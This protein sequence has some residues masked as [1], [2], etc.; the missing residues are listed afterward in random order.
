MMEKAKYWATARVFDEATRSEIAQLIE[1][2]AV[3]ELEERFHSE[4]E[5]GTAGFRGILGAGTARLNRYT[6]RRIIG[7]LGRGL[8]KNSRVGVTYD[9]RRQSAELAHHVAEVLAGFGHHVLLTAKLQPVPLLS[10]L[11]REEECAAG[12]AVTASHNPPEYN[13]IKI[14]GSTGKQLSGDAEKALLAGLAAETDL[15]NIPVKRFDEAVEQGYVESIGRDLENAYLERIR[16]LSVHPEGRENFKIVFTPLHGTTGKLMPRA[17]A[18]FGFRDVVLVPEQADPDGSFPTVRFPNPEEPSALEMALALARTVHADLVLATDPDGDRLGFSVFEKGEYRFL[19]GNDIG[20]LLHEYYLSG[21]KAHGRLPKH[22]L[23]VK[24]LV[25]S[26]L[27]ERIARS[28]GCEVKET[29]TGFKWICQAIEDNPTLSFVCGGEESYGF[30]AGDFIRDKDGISSGCLAAEM[31]AYYHSQGKTLAQVLAELHA[32]HGH[33]SSVVR[34][35]TLPGIEGAE[36]IKQMMARLRGA[37][38]P[39]GVDEV[40][41][42]QSGDLPYPKQNLLQ[43]R[44]A[45]D[46]RVSVRPSG[47]EPKIKFYVY[48]KGDRSEAEALY[49]RFLKLAKGT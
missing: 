1:S 34:N 30:L 21:L 27:Q 28:Y 49:E 39:E 23:V 26:P 40:W 43:Y 31:T 10:F 14:Y 44:F 22:P 13:G 33:W 2:G 7:A 45:N 16:Q 17:L 3:K 9:S 38:K 42:F 15:D 46:A 29:L 48:V 35:L 37:P 12:V 25:T 4:L 8:P 19:E 47:T 41:D 5:Y 18:E 36:Q 32:K 24:S 6:V 20:A 11:V